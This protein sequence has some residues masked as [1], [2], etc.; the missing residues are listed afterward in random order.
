VGGRVGCDCAC[1]C[2]GSTGGG[3]TLETFLFAAVAF[4]LALDFGD[5]GVDGDPVAW[6]GVGALEAGVEA[7][8]AGGVDIAT[9]E[10]VDVEG[11]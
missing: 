11:P 7:G 9:V 10:V 4:G 2:A 8:G 1:G 5:L 3:T 6:V